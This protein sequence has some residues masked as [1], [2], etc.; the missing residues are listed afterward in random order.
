MLK[1]KD[2]EFDAKVLESQ[3]RRGPMLRYYNEYY[4]LRKSYYITGEASG[5]SNP[6]NYLPSHDMYPCFPPLYLDIIQ[7][8]TEVMIEEKPPVIDGS[9][10]RR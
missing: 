6:V 1:D 3:V 5:V 2:K 7:I 8:E 4:K 9:V 10:F